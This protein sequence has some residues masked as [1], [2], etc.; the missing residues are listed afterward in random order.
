MAPQMAPGVLFGAVT[1]RRLHPVRHRFVYPVACLRLPLDRMHDLRVPLLGIDRRH[2]F[3]FRSEDH[4]ARDGTDLATW[5]RAL[6]AQRRLGDICNGEIVLQTF[7]RIFGHVFNPVSFWFCHDRGGALR[8]VLAEVN[9]TFGESHAYLVHHDDLRPIRGGDSLHVDKCFH[10][11][12]FFPVS[13]RYRFRLHGGGRAEWLAIDYLDGGVTR[14]ET[15]IGGRLAPLDGRTMWRWLL[16]Y[17]LMTLAVT[18]RIHW[19]A[20]RLWRRRLPVFA[21][22]RPPIEEITR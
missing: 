18:S 17:P 3:S 8:A 9:N 15:R 2:V 12:P 20:L 11:S 6:L 7:P 1:H 19:Q 4:G 5:V 16:T 13:G 22:P 14:L 10:V 21:K